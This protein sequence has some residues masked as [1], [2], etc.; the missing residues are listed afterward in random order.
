MTKFEN[1]RFLKQNQKSSDYN[2]D[3]KCGEISK[4]EN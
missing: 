1:Y 4:T 2:L 3:V